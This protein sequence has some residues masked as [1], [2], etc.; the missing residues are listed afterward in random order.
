M[1]IKP[2]V[3]NRHGR[4]IFPCNFFPE[5]DF[6]VFETLEQFNAV[7]RRDFGEKAPTETDI[8]RAAHRRATITVA[9]KSA[10]TWR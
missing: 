8:R 5:L 1:S 6:S 10:A 2:F 7:V 4:L 3:I 9:T